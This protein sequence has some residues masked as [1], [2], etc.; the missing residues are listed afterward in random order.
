ML[1]NLCVLAKTLAHQRCNRLGVAIRDQQIDV[2]KRSLQQ[3]VPHRPANEIQANAQLT[4]GVAQAI[5]GFREIVGNHNVELWGREFGH[6]DF[7]DPG[8]PAGLARGFVVFFALPL[9]PAPAPR[10]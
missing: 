3:P 8:G 6:F 5:E 7:P 2:D 4:R 10:G 1:A 9:P